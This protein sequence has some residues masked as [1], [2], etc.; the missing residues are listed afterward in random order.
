[1]WTGK[2]PALAKLAISR[3]IKAITP[4]VPTG[5]MEIAE[6][7]NVPVI[8]HRMAIPNI[9]KESEAPIRTRLFL[10]AEELSSS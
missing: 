2:A 8:F 7:R 4:I 1:M 10:A 6:S 9:R 5:G 3:E